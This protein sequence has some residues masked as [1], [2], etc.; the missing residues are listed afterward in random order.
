MGKP[1]KWEHEINEFL[2]T[3]SI[4]DETNNGERNNDAWIKT[5]KDQKSWKK[6]RKQFCNDDSIS[7]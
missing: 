4:E 7:T 3:E 6:N 1:K 2:R 5:A